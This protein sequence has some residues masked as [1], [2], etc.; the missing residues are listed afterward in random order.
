MTDSLSSSTPF[1]DLPPALRQG[2]EQFNSG[3]FYACHDTLEALWMEAELYSRPFYQGILQI[4]VAFYHLG[5]SNWQGAAI[6]LG[7]GTNRLYPFEPDYGGIDVANLIDQSES[8]LSTLQKVGVEGVDSLAAIINETEQENE[9][10]IA[11]DELK[12]PQIRVLF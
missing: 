4:A 12:L 5:N 11:G 8:W 2:I 6:L 7:E 3:Q 1:D 10:A 9:A